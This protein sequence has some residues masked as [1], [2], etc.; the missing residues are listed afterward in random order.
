MK[1]SRVSKEPKWVCAR[2]AMARSY[3]ANAAVKF[4]HLGT[5]KNPAD[6]LTKPLSCAKLA[7]F[8]ASILGLGP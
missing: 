7:R 6:L 5:L 1:S 8:R 3:V 2:L 4:G